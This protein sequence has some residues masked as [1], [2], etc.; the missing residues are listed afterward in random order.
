MNNKKQIISSV[1]FFGALWGI[2]E[3]T[4][5]YILHFLPIFISG[6]ILFPIVSFILYKAYTITRSKIS[7][8]FIGVVAAGI[9]SINLF[10]PFFSPFKIINPMI[11]IILE[12]LMVVAVIGVLSKDDIKSKVSGFVL[13]SIGW[14]ALYLGYMGIQYLTTGFV[15]SY[16]VTFYAAFEYTVL[17]GLLSA[18]LAFGFHYLDTYVSK[19]TKRSIFANINPAISLTVFVLAIIV[20]IFA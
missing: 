11:S 7:L 18:G 1:I 6:T 5:G 15:S 16:L 14:R 19:N 12:S 8:V 17:F 13:A 3:A 20:T 9:K 10:L 2:I 4:L